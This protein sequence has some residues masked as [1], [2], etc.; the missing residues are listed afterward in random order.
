MLHRLL[1]FK[2]HVSARVLDEER[3]FL[4]GGRDPI[5]LLGRGYALVA[6]LVDGRHTIGA[7]IGALAE[8]APAPEVLFALM[9]LEQQGFLVEGDSALSPE[10]AAYWEAQGVSASHAAERLSATPIRVHGLEGA[11]AEPVAVALRGAGAVV[12]ESGSFHVVVVDDYLDPSLETFN[13]DALAQNLSW[14]LVKPGGLAA[15]AGPVFRPGSGP[16][17]A[18]L[19]HRLRVNRPVDAY[20]KRHSKEGVT[21]LRPRA[22]VPASV[23]AGASFGALA[24]ARWIV[25][26]ERGSLESLLTLDLSRPTIETHGAPRLPQCPACGDSAL[27]TA[28]EQA[29]VEIR[30]RSKRFTEDG[31]HRTVT[32][33]E[34]WARLGK[35]VS[36]LTGFVTSVWP[37]P[38]RDHPLRPVYG[39]AYSICPAHTAPSFE[40]FRRISMGKGRAPTQARASALG[41]AIERH[42]AVFRDDLVR[43]RTSLDELGDDGIHLNAMQLFSEAQYAAREEINARASGDSR[44]VP[45]PFEASSV[46]DWSPVWSLTHGRRRWAPTAFCY[47]NTPVAPAE[48]YCYFNPNGHASGN[49]LEEAVLHAFFELV[50][51]DAVA[52]WWYNKLARP[53]VDLSSFQQPYF[54]ELEEHYRSLGYRIWVLDITTDLGIPAFCTLAL[55]EDGNRWCVGFGCHRDARLGVQRALTELNQLFDPTADPPPVPWDVSDV[56]DRS[57]LLPDETKPARKMSDFPYVQRDDLRDEVMDCVAAA[58]RAGL[59]TLVL[60]QTRPD[61]EMCAVKVI[62]PGMRHFWPRF[63]P[64]RL[65]E[66]P[67]KMGL[68][69]RAITEAEIN[70]VPLFP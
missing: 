68:S 56:V 19:A 4:L 15:W 16:C 18:C 28:R 48:R 43:R 67:V 17:W 44:R 62:V 33:E 50:E 58:A 12:A 3:V 29:P 11:R 8:R 64:G 26:G 24:I 14:T 35:H 22:E 27:S 10:A 38:E 52:I 32:P 23:E 55:R 36:P 37:I 65:Y 60:D 69:E 1:R 34:T 51:R 47:S 66:I 13:R 2:R 49:C 21:P 61:I 45:L 53:R 7:I 54:V 57:F 41:E 30:S 59:E 42:S 20:L 70:A 5:M 39:A 6:P 25:D 63:G 9:R 46:V 40:D 31:G